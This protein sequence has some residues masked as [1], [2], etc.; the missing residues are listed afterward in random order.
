MH[1]Y[2][3]TFVPVCMYCCTLCINV[4]NSHP[5]VMVPVSIALMVATATSFIAVCPLVIF[6]LKIEVLFPSATYVFS[7]SSKAPVNL[8][9]YNAQSH[10]CSL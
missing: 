7:T 1:V 8:V 9:S 3:R 2:V 5:L 4:L 6:F 10:R